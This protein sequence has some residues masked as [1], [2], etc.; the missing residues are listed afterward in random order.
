M[1]GEDPAT[2]EQAMGELRRAVERQLGIDELAGL[3]T[4]PT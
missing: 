4:S 2:V 1:T 3:R